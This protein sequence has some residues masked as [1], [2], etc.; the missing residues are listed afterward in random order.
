MTAI[1][2]TKARDNIYQILADVNLN[3]QPI[4]IQG[5]IQ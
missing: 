5:I 2:V 4:T 1:N 3:S